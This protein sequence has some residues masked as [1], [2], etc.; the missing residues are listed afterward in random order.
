MSNIIKSNHIFHTDKPFPI[1]TSE[2]KAAAEAKTRNRVKVSLKDAEMSSEQSAILQETEEMVIDILDK[3][4]IEANSLIQ[5]AREEAEQI[6]NEAL[7]SASQLEEESQQKGYSRGREIIYR[8]L[9][10]DR[11]KIS[12]THQKIISEAEQEKISIIK[13]AEQEIVTLG[14]EVARKIVQSE[15]KQDKA[16]ILNIVKA[17]IREV[18]NSNTVKI[19]IN[20]EY[21]EIVDNSL[22]NII[23]EQGIKEITIES[24]NNLAIGDCIVEADGEVVDARI[25]TVINNIENSFSEY[26]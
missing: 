6:K 21:V 4:R 19:N 22:K 15:L 8:E 20:P 26:K 1:K 5:N 3:A 12:E 16:K 9:E 24:S 17:V 11:K 18:A 25:E 23:G 14:I 7:I 10:N 13:S 2:I